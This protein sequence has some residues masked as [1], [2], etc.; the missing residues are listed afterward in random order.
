MVDKFD[1]SLNTPGDEEWGQRVYAHGLPLIYAD[2]VA[3]Q[4]PARRTFKSLHKKI[5]RITFRYVGLLRERSNRPPW[6][7]YKFYKRLFIFPTP[8]ECLAV[9]NSDLN[10]WQK[11]KVLIV[12]FWTRS[13]RAFEMV[14]ALFSQRNRLW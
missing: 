5:K 8:D 4:H 13:I 12:L 3:I 11:F 7:Q 9:F 1:G 10:I 2:D 6:L 14:H